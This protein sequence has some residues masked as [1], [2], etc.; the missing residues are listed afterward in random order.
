MLLS[1]CNIATYAYDFEVDGIYYNITSSSKKT[2]SVTYKD[3]N[4]NSYSGIVVIPSDVTHNGITYSVNSIGI[5]AFEDCVE[6]TYVT[7]P[8]SVTSI[9][10]RVFWCCSGLISVAIPNSVTSIEYNAFS[11]CSSLNSVIIPNSVTRIGERAFSSCSGLTSITIPNSVTSIGDA[12]F[13]WCSGLTSITISN[14]VT[15]IGKET[16]SYCSSLTSVTIPNS[17]TNIGNNAFQYCKSLTS[18]IIPNSVTSIGKMA[19]YSCYNLASVTIPNSVTSI[20]ELAFGRCSCLTSVTI[21]NS[22]TSIGRSPFSSCQLITSISVEDGNPN[23]DSRTNCNA[24]I[25]TST[26]T[27]ISGCKNTSIPNSV[28][29]IGEWAFSGCSGLTSITIPNSVTSIGEYAFSECSSLSSVTIPNSVTSVGKEAFYRCSG[30]TSV[31][32]P[33]SVT[34][35]EEYTFSQ[36]YSLTTITNR[37]KKPQILGGW[38]FE[39]YGTLHVLKGYKEVYSNVTSDWKK[40]KIVD[41]LD[42]VFVEGLTIDVD[43][44]HFDVNVSGLRAKATPTNEDADD[45][46]VTWSTTTPSVMMVIPTTGDF[47]GL[48]DGVGE[49]VATAN[50]GSGVVAKAKVYFG[51]AQPPTI[52]V[53]SINITAGKYEMAVGERQ[54]LEA[55]VLPTNASQKTIT[56]SST[57]PNIVSIDSYGEITAL[58]SG[59]AIIIATATDGSGVSGICTITVKSAVGIDNI[60]ADDNSNDCNIYTI[61][62]LKVKGNNLP[63]GIYI[64]NGKK[65]VMK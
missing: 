37:A 11:G 64:K 60:N 25:E 7:I 41:D 15:S 10:G 53:A 9:E 44:Q 30:L 62:G 31:T 47:L 32:I 34:R 26:S 55:T 33:N 57:A 35:I 4:Y 40:F 61:N 3:S 49:L 56:W 65:V 8:N 18:V 2:V 59:T 24:I 6:L 54:T 52:Q 17:V 28:T 13:S 50:D 42:E 43:N 14:S 1:F 51:A 22:V 20:G 46:S 27:L 21:P 36:C 19:F 23:Y 38:V 48:T 45:W 29:N 5:S 39:K 63:A 16:F 12:A 58:K